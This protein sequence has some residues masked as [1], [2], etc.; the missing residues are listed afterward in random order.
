[1]TIASDP[2]AGQ[3]HLD[4]RIPIALVIAIGIQTLAIG[5]W[6]GSIDTR[7]AALEAAQQANTDVRE[8]VIRMEEQ[9]KYIRQGVDR[10]TN[11]RDRRER[12]LE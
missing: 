6:V 12:G 10:L 11:G 5:T 1:M 4:K 2:G 9:L 8:R 7:V 3:W